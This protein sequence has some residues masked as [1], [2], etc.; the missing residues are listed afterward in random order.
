MN[1]ESEMNAAHATVDAA[2]RRIAN[3]PAPEGLEDRVHQALRS[4]PRS[5]R[6]IAWPG[7]MSGH[8]P[9]RIGDRPWVR[10]AAAA[11]IAFVVVGGGWGIYSRVQPAKV[12]AM[13]HVAGP[14]NGF[15]NANAMRTP[16][17]VNGPVINHPLA[18]QPAEP[19]KAAHP[20]REQKPAAP[21]VGKMPPRQ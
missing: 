15:S 21:P 11:A 3:L 16:Q 2:L 19:D 17:T 5:G 14:G 8:A 10:S 13:P 20:G 4:A 18:Q 12:I 6:V 7:R 1:S 9:G